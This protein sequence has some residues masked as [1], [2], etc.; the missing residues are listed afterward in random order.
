MS[1]IF[2]V[3]NFKSIFYLNYFQNNIIMYIIV[4]TQIS[5][6]TFWS[7]INIIISSTPGTLMLLKY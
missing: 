4:M 7:F 2:L 3:S 5:S 6:Y 1:T